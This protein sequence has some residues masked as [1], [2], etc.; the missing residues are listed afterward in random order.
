MSDEEWIKAIN[1]TKEEL[2]EWLNEMYKDEK[3]YRD[4]IRNYEKD[5]ATIYENKQDIIYNPKTLQNE[6]KFFN[7]V[8]TKNFSYKK[9]WI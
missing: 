2:I 6:I 3:V 5:Y 4:I 8:F 1:S 7:E 9:N